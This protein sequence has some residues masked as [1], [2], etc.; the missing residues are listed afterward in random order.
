ML[1]RDLQFSEDEKR[2][3]NVEYDKLKFK[4]TDL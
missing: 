3:I 1:Y 2:A 4:I